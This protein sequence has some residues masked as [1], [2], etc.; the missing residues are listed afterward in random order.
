AIAHADMAPHG[1]PLLAVLGGEL[2]EVDVVVHQRLAE[3][4]GLMEARP[5][6]VDLAVLRGIADVLHVAVPG[7]LEPVAPPTGAAA[8]LVSEG[9]ELVMP[10]VAQPVP[11]GDAR[12]RP[13]LA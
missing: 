8:V 1:T 4:D 12:E 6:D 11:R 3:I 2:G 10:A 5:R 13:R 9:A 7:E